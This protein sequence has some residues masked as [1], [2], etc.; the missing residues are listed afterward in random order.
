MTRK[1]QKKNEVFQLP[2]EQIREIYKEYAFDDVDELMEYDDLTLDYINA[3]KKLEI[4]ERAILS[5]YAELK[6]QRK[7]ADL[8]GVSRTTV[9]KELNKIKEKLN[10]NL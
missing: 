4:P 7:T 3:F 6:S 8:L 2:K 5:L 1:E 10:E 9:I